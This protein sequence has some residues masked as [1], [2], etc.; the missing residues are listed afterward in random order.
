MGRLLAA[1]TLLAAFLAPLPPAAAQPAAR[2]SNAPAAPLRPVAA[3]VVPE[4]PAVTAT[5]AVLWDPVDDQV[6]WGKEETQ[7][8]PP[9]STTKI[10]TVLLAL[11]AGALG[12]TVTVSAV[13]AEVGRR[14]GAA[15]LGLD[16]GQQVPMRSLLQGLVLRS[17]ND[18]AVAVAEHVA[19]SEEA[20]VEKM[21]ARAAEMGLTDTQFLNATGLTDDLDH[22][23]SAADLALLAEVAMDNR[24]FASWAGADRMNVASFGLLENRNELLGQ[25]PGATGVKTG[26]TNLAGL[27]LVAS[28]T[29][30]G[31][32]LIAVVLDSEASFSDT[33]KILDH[34]YDDYRR[35]QPARA[36][37]RVAQYRWSRER[38]GL[39]A[40]EAI[41]KTL[42]RPQ[43][44]SWRVLLEP[45][46]ALPV[47]QGQTL[48]R[49]ELVVDGDVVAQTP[50]TAARS[51]A[52]PPPRPAAATAGGAVQE[53]LRDFAVLYP[54]DRDA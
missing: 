33:I 44:A 18:A 41:G 31:R 12:D 52:A 13:A 53:A 30:D 9:A 35:A 20:F 1:L 48:G 22:R 40:V 24:D 3:Q 2:V 37:E 38:V 15:T 5:G 23:S 4:G 39:R 54:V 43:D 47:E 8:L 42:P 11:E 50:L 26:F 14:P 7:P 16:A 51:V 21:N 10:M 34:G 28:A 46:V 49:A 29:R 45:S 17:G 25:Y 32:R 19:G 36:G 6:L 27:C